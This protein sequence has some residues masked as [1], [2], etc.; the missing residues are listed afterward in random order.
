M[1]DERE[2]KHYEIQDRYHQV[3]LRLS[4]YLQQRPSTSPPN[5]QSSS[6]GPEI[7]VVLPK[8]KLKEFHS[9]P[10]NCTRFWNQFSTSVHSRNDI[11]DVTKYIYLTQCIKGTA[12][13][14]LEGFRGEACDHGDAIEALKDM[15]GDK[16]KI[17]RTLIRSLINLSKPK[18]VRSEIFDFKVDMESMFMQLHHDPDTEVSAN[19]MLLREL[20][21]MKLPKE[22]EDFWL[23][24]YKTM[25]FSQDQIKRGLQHL[26]NCMNTEDKKGNQKGSQV[27]T[28]P[29]SQ[30]QTSGSS[31][32]NSSNAIGTYTALSDYSCIYCKGKH[33]PYECT[34]YSSL[35]SRRERLKVLKSCIKCTKGTSG[36]RMYHSSQ[37]M[38]SFQKGETSFIPLG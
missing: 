35:S 2:A 1:I 27:T 31:S 10:L 7:K 36:Y 38:P 3:Q 32:S 9:D 4:L 12:Q 16:D 37:C 11:E 24:I 5:S 22:E 26:L 18:Y 21:I 33:G 29:N 30:S 14:V 6:T 34:N 8:I 23:N 25:Y 19:E 28:K 13:K 17:Q 15:H 20:I